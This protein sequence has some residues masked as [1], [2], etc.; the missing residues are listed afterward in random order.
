[1]SPTAPNPPWGLTLGSEGLLDLALPCTHCALAT[2]VP[3]LTSFSLLRCHLYRE[4]FPDRAIVSPFLPP[5]S[6]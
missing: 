4:A 2:R 6:S 3:L 1:M 5:L